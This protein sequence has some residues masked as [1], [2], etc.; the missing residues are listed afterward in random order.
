[1]SPTRLLP[2]CTLALCACG[3]K[4][5]TPDSAALAECGDIDGPEGEVP[6]VLG[7]WTASFG[8]SMFDE[9]CGIAGITQGPDLFLDG[10]MEIQGRVPD[11][12][13]VTFNGLGDE[14]RFFGLES[15]S[16]G[17]TFSGEH[18]TADGTYHVAFGG[19]VYY[20]TYRGRNYIEGFAFLGV[21]LN[22]DGSIDCDMRG[23]WSAAKSGA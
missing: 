14:V 13:Y 18:T 2:V 19:L 16:G 15:A 8:T 21:D 12:L 1:M 22:G 4:E 6:N 5:S 10:A 9:S 11:T 23:E 20:D 7:N 3:D 17:V